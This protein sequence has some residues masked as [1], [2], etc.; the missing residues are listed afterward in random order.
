MRRAE[1]SGTPGL[2][3][4]DFQAMD[5]IFLKLRVIYVV[6]AALD[7]SRETLKPENLKNHLIVKIWDMWSP[8]LLRSDTNND[9]QK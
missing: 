6:P 8:S 1:D 9:H 4:G 7:S 5:V 2:R 3:L